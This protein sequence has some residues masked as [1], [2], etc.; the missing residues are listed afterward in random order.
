M[1]HQFTTL[2]EQRDQQFVNQMGASG[3]GWPSAGTHPEK[4]LRCD[5]PTWL[6]LHITA[7]KLP[8][9]VRQRKREVQRKNADLV[10]ADGNWSEKYSG[11]K[12]DSVLVHL[13]IGVIQLRRW[14]SRASLW[15]RRKLYSRGVNSRQVLLGVPSAKHFFVAWQAQTI[16]DI[17]AG[18]AIDSPAVAPPGRAVEKRMHLGNCS[19]GNILEPRSK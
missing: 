7:A 15:S 14:Q 2:R 17:N 5:P 18:F 6:Y 11:F 12:T 13:V 10:K 19:D 1:G 16:W 9:D 3:L 4:T 8:P